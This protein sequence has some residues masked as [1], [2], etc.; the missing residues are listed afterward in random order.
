MLITQTE[1]KLEDIRDD[2][3][4]EGRSRK[5]QPPEEGIF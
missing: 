1:R 3:E 5:L 2:E 4:Q